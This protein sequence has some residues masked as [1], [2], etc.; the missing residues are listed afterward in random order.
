[1]SDS[2]LRQGT[3]VRFAFIDEHRERFPVRLMCAVPGVTRSGYY[4]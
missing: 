1:M 3:A 2:L 4:A